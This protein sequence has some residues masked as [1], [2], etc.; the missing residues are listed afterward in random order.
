ME[1]SRLKTQAWPKLILLLLGTPFFV[2]AE[3]AA[4]EPASV[5]FKETRTV[6]TLSAEERAIVLQEMRQFLH[7]TQQIVA[8]LAEDDMN[9]VT[10]GARLSGRSAQQRAPQSLAAKLPDAFKTLGA[11]THRR[12]D[13]MALDADQFGDTEH[14]LSQLNRLLKNCVSCHAIYRISTPKN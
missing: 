9:A 3:Q 13:A 5:A 8:G 10:D 14:A 6:I 4:N 11:D 7:S 12:F 1:Q 2:H